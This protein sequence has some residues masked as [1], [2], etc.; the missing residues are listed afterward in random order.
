MELEGGKSGK[1]PFPHKLHQER[2]ADCM[3]CHGLFPQESGALERLKGDGTLKSKQVMNKLCVKCH[4]ELKKAKQPTGPV[5]C[6]K[7]HIK[8]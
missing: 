3:T 4:R 1:V 5:T 8:G 7:C 6:K 2:Q